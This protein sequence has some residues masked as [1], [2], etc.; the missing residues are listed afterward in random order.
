MMEIFHT[1]IVSNCFTIRCEVI[2]SSLCLALNNCHLKPALL[3]YSPMEDT[4]TS[5]RSW[6]FSHMFSRLFWLFSSQQFFFHHLGSTW[7]L[8]VRRKPKVKTQTGFTI[9][10][11]HDLF[12]TTLRHHFT[13]SAKSCF[14]ARLTFYFLN[15]F[16]LY[17]PLSCIKSFESNSFDFGSIVNHF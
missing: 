9:N 17:A 12:R 8:E 6:R 1:L 14:F 16:K 5:S 15:I 13:L 3:L 7:E 4:E 11:L 10:S 2:F